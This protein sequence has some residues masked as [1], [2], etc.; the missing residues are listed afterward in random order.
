MQL[1][2]DNQYNFH[3]PGK[4]K[5]SCVKAAQSNTITPYLCIFTSGKTPIV[6]LDGRRGKDPSEDLSTVVKQI[7]YSCNAVK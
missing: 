3:V 7:L 2:L 5:T 1:D 6:L 4:K